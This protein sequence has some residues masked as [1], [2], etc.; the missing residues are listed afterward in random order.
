[1]TH[2]LPIVA[3]DGPVGSGKSTVAKLAAHRSG[4]QFISSGAMY[5]AVALRARQEDIALD[6]E[7]RLAELA[8]R[9]TFRFTTD[10]DG[11]DHTFLDG[12]DV[13][14]ALRH[15]EIAE[16]ASVVATLP[17]V[18]QALVDKLRSYGV[19]G[20]IVMEGR[21][22]QTVVFPD[23]DLKI[24]L[25]A[26][27]EE[28]A[29]RRR[30]EHAARGEH[31]DLQQVLD[32]VI[33]RD[34]RDSERTCAPLKAADEAIRVDTDGRTVDEVVEC[35]VQLIETWRSRPSWRGNS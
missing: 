21:D 30:Q 9:L 18:R 5:R 2:R 32:D 27:A 33:A 8:R 35:L 10:V 13:T 34:K 24:Y 7:T 19:D 15:Q 22:I 11:L 28:R 17:A 26:G 20:G 31:T 29:R 25:H 4:L 1:M 12:E 23:A 3:I 14:H 6:E 16:G